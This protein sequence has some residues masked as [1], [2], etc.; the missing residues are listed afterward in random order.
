MLETKVAKLD[1]L[2]AV[3]FDSKHKFSNE[4]CLFI[5]A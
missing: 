3:F 5:I 4:T 2:L 1:I